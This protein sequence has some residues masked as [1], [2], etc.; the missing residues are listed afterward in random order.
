MRTATCFAALTFLFAATAVA[1]PSI[2]AKK[3]KGQIVA[4]DQPLPMDGDEAAIADALKKAAKTTIERS[5]TDPWSVHFVGFLSKKPG[6]DKISLLVYDIG[7]GK[8]EY[9]TTKEIS[10]EKDATILASSVEL[11]EE[12]GVKPGTKAELVLATFGG[13]QVDLAKVKLTFK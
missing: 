7:S 9:L 4:S 10:V 2:L 5:G 3:Y 12:D 6:T 11:S 1:A 8:R 13:K